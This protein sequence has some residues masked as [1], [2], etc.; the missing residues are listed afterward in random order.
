LRRRR[1][2]LVINLTEGDRGAL[3]ARLSGAR[4]RVGYALPRQSRWKRSCYTHTIKMVTSPRHTVEKNLDA[5]RAIGLFPGAEER[6]LSFAIPEAAR[7]RIAL[8]QETARPYILIHPTS[9]W[10]FKCLPTATIAALIDALQSQG[11]NVI[12]SSGPA[13]TEL[14]MVEAIL[15]RC[16]SR[17]LSLAGKLSLKEL[18][19]LVERASRL[20]CVDSLPLHIAS[21][22]KTP[23]VAL[24]GPSS[25]AHWGPWLH[26]RSR[27]VASP[28][29]CRPCFMDGC[30]GSKVSDCLHQ[31]SVA[32]ILEGLATLDVLPH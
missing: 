4:Y 18:G 26:P 5:L 7:E 9:R 16:T 3:A 2:D 25:E 21:A 15:Q 6:G 29:R 24:F 14:E 20:I 11:R 27:V 1:Y 8:W 13:P 30:A 28:F 12:L 10:R 17:P 23:V 22:L 19:A 32:Q 31:L